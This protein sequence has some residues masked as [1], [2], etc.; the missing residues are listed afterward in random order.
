[1]KHGA[2]PCA[3]YYRGPDEINP[4]RPK[5]WNEWTRRWSW[6]PGVYAMAKREGLETY[7]EKKKCK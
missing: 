2:T 7:Q 1:L 3:M 5:Q 4:K 6:Q